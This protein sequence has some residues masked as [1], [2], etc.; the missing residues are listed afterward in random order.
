MLEAQGEGQEVLFKCMPVGV[1]TVPFISHHYSKTLL[2]K[3]VFNYPTLLKDIF[4]PES[5]IPPNEVA[6]FHL[7]DVT[8]LNLAE[9]QV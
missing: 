8:V 9:S 6:W 7:T 3:W 1:D 2:R 5:F 4:S